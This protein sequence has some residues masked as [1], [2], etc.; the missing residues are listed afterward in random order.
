LKLLCYLTDYTNI[1]YSLANNA[2]CTEKSLDLELLIITAKLT[3]APTIKS[4]I[5]YNYLSC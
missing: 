3:A 4:H 2:Q 1:R 5:V